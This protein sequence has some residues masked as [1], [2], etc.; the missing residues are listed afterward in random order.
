MKKRLLNIIISL[1]IISLI[2]IIL[3]QY[4]WIK[5]AMDIREKQFNRSVS[6]ALS[7]AVLSLET[8]EDIRFMK[9]SLMGDSIQT[10]VQAFVQDTIMILNDQLDSLL[11]TDDFD[12]PPPPPPPP[13]N[14]S[15]TSSPNWS[16]GLFLNY[17]ITGDFYADE[18]NLHEYYPLRV[19]IPDNINEYIIEY[20]QEMEISGSDT[21]IREFPS[22]KLV[23]THSNEPGRKIKV[24]QKA[25]TSYENAKKGMEWKSAPRMDQLKHP[26]DPGRPGLVPDRAKDVQ[27]GVKKITRKAQK[28]KDVIKKIAVEL[29]NKPVPLKERID[30]Q[31]LERVLTKAL[32][33]RNITQPY[34]FSILSP[35]SKTEPLP[36]KSKGFKTE[37]LSTTHR[38]SLFPNDIIQ[39]PD[40][41]LVFFP[42]EKNNFLRSLSWLMLGSVLFTLVIAGTSILSIFFMLRQKKIS[43]IKTDFI[44]NM[45]HE[46]KTPIAT[47]SVAVDSINNPKVLAEPEV[48]KN[49]TRVIK[50]ENNRMNTRVEQVLQMALLD[51][52]EFQLIK[53]PLDVNALVRK[54]TSHFML[55]VE[56]REGILKVFTEAENSV[57]MADETHLA[58]VLNNLLDNAYK[59]SPGKPD[60]IVKTLNSNHHLRIFIEDKGMGMTPETRLKIFDKF[61]RVTSGNIHNVKGFGLGLSYSKAIILAHKGEIQVKSELGK[62]STFEISLPLHIPDEGLT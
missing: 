17:G 8:R 55:L 30:D 52:S 36:V 57:V 23:I 35:D 12:Y 25:I 6:E 40:Q 15:F 16:Q 47:I 51:S 43:D 33:D 46:F 5:N 13:D 54:V 58:N 50:E 32:A 38:T 2:G 21:I 4:F 9:R 1:I 45:T 53:K 44:N 27:K 11:S 48:I 61:Y 26:G 18:R 62:G 24:V 3:V 31:K 42:G 41:L 39:K 19:V 49:F 59:Y 29:E 60:I 22:G 14:F 34:E 28:I 20:N 37:Y 56:S 7:S 10:L